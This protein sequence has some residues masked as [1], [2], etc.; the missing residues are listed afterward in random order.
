MFI[1][2][3]ILLVTAALT[4]T[5]LLAGALYDA[6]H[7]LTPANP[8]L[9]LVVHH[10]RMGLEPSPVRMLALV[11]GAAPAK[12][13]RVG[14]NPF[15]DEPVPGW[16]DAFQLTCADFHQCS[17]MREDCERYVDYSARE[18][19]YHSSNAFGR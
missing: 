11:D 9:A 8:M 10:A 17:D 3:L 1:L 13:A 14:R 5:V 7:P 12:T 4:V 18:A 19:R 16:A 2:T 15:V 6:L